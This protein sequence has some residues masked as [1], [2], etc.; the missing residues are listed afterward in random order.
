[1]SILLMVSWTFLLVRHIIFVY[2]QLCNI[3]THL[4]NCQNRH[5]S[6]FTCIWIYGCGK[7]K[8]WYHPNIHSKLGQIYWFQLGSQKFSKFFFCLYTFSVLCDTYRRHQEEKC[9]DKH[10]QF[11][12]VVN[13]LSHG[14][15]KFWPLGSFLEVFWHLEC[16]KCY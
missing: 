6:S 14:L 12:M 7:K 8:S 16:K 4:W 15:K 3:L 5:N 11:T 13:E 2:E 1:M 9:P 10:P